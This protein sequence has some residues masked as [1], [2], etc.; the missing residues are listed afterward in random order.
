[1]QNR[2]TKY[3]KMILENRDSKDKAEHNLK[4]ANIPDH[5]NR[6]LIIGDS[7][8]RNRNTLLGLI[9]N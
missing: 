9:N 6:I 1:M 7:V 4:W 5:P 8:S 2:D 3:I